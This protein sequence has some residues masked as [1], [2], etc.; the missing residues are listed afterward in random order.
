MSDSVTIP[1]S[2][3]NISSPEASSV[4]APIVPTAGVAPGG[5]RQLALPI[6]ISVGFLGIQFVWAV[7][8]TQVSPLLESMGSQAWLTGLIWAAGPVTGVLVQPIVGV[9]SDNLRS[10][11][12]RRRPFLLLGALTTAIALICMPHSPNLLVAAIWLWVLDASINL[13]Q[14]PYRALVPDVV[15]RAQQTTAYSLMSLTIGLGAVVSTFIASQIA[16]PQLVFYLGAAAILIALGWTALTTRERPTDKDPV[17]HP[18]GQKSAIGAITGILGETLMAIP[19]MP[20]EAL[21]LCVA[22]SFTWFGLMCLFIFFS[23]FIPKQ[24]FHATPGT[25]L[26]NDGV[27]WA[28]SC[29]TALNLSCFVVSFGISQL[30]RRFSKKA[31]HTAALVLMA[32]SFIAL[33]FISTPIQA[34]IAMACI[35]FGWA[36]TLSIPFALL[37]DHM[38]KGKEGLLMGTF[39]IFIAA[40]GVLCTLLVGQIISRFAGG[41][42]GVAFVIGGISV[43]IS[44]LLLQRVHEAP[45]T[46]CE[47]GP[48]ALGAH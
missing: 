8:M 45:E 18:N 36:T 29:Q 46:H 4:S 30:C 2:A 12:G 11:L 43:L 31:T 19:R 16:V 7:Q 23:V 41:N 20:K 34:M 35:G 32:V 47:E 17:V 9:L 1:S 44:A 22:H 28:A 27:R 42:E 26:Y 25:D 3:E 24:I 21:K 6:N 10:R 33:N 15:P 39:N 48:P 37:T 38:P 5:I 14:G 13:T 40:P